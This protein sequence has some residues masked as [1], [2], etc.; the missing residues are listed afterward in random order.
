[1]SVSKSSMVLYSLLCL[2]PRMGDSI[3]CVDL[4]TPVSSSTVMDVADGFE[5]T[6]RFLP[7]SNFKF[8]LYMSTSDAVL[9]I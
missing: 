9:G 7:S 8:S 6:A 1:M 5:G 4:L 2:K 3:R